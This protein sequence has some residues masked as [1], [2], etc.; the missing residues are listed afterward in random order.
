MKQT[1]NGKDNGNVNLHSD[2]SYLLVLFRTVNGNANV[3][4]VLPA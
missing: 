1:V 3:I 2:W 4:F